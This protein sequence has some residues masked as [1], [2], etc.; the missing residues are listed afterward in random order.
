MVD[1]NIVAH[2]F[3]PEYFDIKQVRAGVLGALMGAS[4]KMLKDYESYV[5]TWHDAP[6]FKREIVYKGGDII[7]ALSTDHEVFWYLENGTHT[8][9]V[10]MT[11]DFIPKTAVR[12]VKSGKGRGGVEFFN[13]RANYGG[14]EPR[15][16]TDVIQ[17]R[18][19]EYTF[20]QVRR[21]IL[22]NIKKTVGRGGI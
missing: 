13:G 1:V 21:A 18:W 3:K 4:N 16:I 7:M 19:E 8:R 22:R 6:V 17:K 2:P 9:H 20:V 15:R 10:K 5:G 12:R 14:I 11:D